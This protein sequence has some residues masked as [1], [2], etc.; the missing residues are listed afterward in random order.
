MM[1]LP[2]TPLLSFIIPTYKRP[3][4]LDRLLTSILVQKGYIESFE[5]VVVN[6]CMEESLQIEEICQ[7]FDRKGLSVRLFH[8]PLPGGSQ[9]RNMGIENAHGQWL[10]FIDD[11]EELFEGYLRS[12][13]SIL[14]DAQV[15]WLIGG[16]YRPVFPEEKGSWIKN[17]YYEVNF[18]E[19]PKELKR[20]HLPGGNLIISSKF[21]EMIG[22][23]SP[24]LGHLGNISGYGEDTELTMRAEK[25][26]AIQKY[27]PNLGVYHYIPAEKLSLQ[28]LKKQKRLSSISKARLYFQFNPPNPNKLKR[29]AVYFY[30]LKQTAWTYARYV[31]IRLQLPFRNKQS[32][33]FQENYWVEVVLPSYAKFRIN[34]ELCRTIFSV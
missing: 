25:A 27:Y 12:V 20:E 24:H 2:G 9:A 8:Q 30:Y 22:V 31:W 26:G 11:D 7:D 4:G 28:W 21:I 15:N 5:V 13:F 33:P 18:G 16:P 6:N 23:F 34:L 17:K 29:I 32:F 10:A 14:S 3:Q 1:S 19:Q